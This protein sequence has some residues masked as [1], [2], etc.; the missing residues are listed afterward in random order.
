[1][2]FRQDETR[3]EKQASLAV[4][5]LLLPPSTVP[6]GKCG[7]TLDVFWEDTMFYVWCDDCEWLGSVCF[8]NPAL[9]EATN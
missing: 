6:C 3:D 2:L 7:V 9:V 4:Q 5:C 1:M 8:C